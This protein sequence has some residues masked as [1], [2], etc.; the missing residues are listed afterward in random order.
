MKN[1]KA[2]IRLVAALFIIV[3]ISSLTW[4]TQAKYVW[5]EREQSF[6][7]KTAE[8]EIST[9]A[10]H[11]IIV[12]NPDIPT[13]VVQYT[14]N[15]FKTE[16]PDQ[17]STKEIRYQL[18][19]HRGDATDEVNWGSENEDFD[20]TVNDEACPGD[21]S[22]VY[23]MAPDTKQEQIKGLR[24]VWTSAAQMAH[25]E[26]VFVKVK[27]L[28]PYEKIYTFKITILSKAKILI[29]P[30]N[31][32]DPFGNGI[33]QLSFMTSGSF[34]A[35]LP[36]HLMKVR[37]E[38]NEYVDI[39]DTNDWIQAF[40]SDPLNDGS[41]VN[42]SADPASRYFYVFLEPS[43]FVKLNFYKPSPDEDRGKITARVEIEEA[44]VP[45]YATWD[46][47]HYNEIDGLYGWSKLPDNNIEI[48]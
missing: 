37:L 21:L 2:L 44:D 25:S 48:P 24:F 22:P 9:D 33:T 46:N 10:A 15:N 1:S 5:T 18:S 12:Y 4:Y 23:T 42:G 28:A 20:F 3:L 16:T 11:K 31:M 29:T 27:V 32:S 35:S 41:I 17:Y 45:Y 6:D 7:L 26:F 34:G 40:I 47:T 30:H 38:W 8:F 43:A 36:T 39:D 19:I 14:F 13:T